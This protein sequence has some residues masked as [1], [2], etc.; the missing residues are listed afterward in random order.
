MNRFLVWM[1]IAC[2]GLAQVAHA[3]TPVKIACVRTTPHPALLDIA[4]EKGHLAEEGAGVELVSAATGK[5]ALDQLL[6]GKVAMAAA[7]ETP[8]MAAILRGAD[9]AVVA[10][11]FKSDRSEMILAR[12]DAA[13]EK[14]ADLVGKR[15]GLTRGTSQEFFFETF[16]LR[17]GIPG[18]RLTV[19]DLRPD[20][21]SKGIMEGTLDAIVTAIPRAPRLK[22]ALGEKGFLFYGEGFYSETYNLVTT[23]RFAET[24][25]KTVRQILKALYRAERFA[26]AEP[27]AAQA[28]VARAIG[29][30]ANNLRG[31]WPDL[32]LRVSLNQALVTNLEHQ[33]RWAIRN[34]LTTVTSP[35]DFTG[36]IAEK[37]LREIAPERVTLY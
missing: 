6:E 30:E 23:R 28:I 16:L 1:A 15:I 8:I 24:E 14:P 25:G 34:K 4:L 32:Q 7:A 9:I 13:I 21:Y 11:I 18:N 20:E 29:E 3:E 17:H 10:T 26:L 33:A 37:F 2:L 35:P 22:R 12:R 27:A 5:H 31:Y 19:V 36:W